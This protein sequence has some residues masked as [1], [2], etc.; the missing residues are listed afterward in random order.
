MAFDDTDPWSVADLQTY[1]SGIMGPSH[2]APSQAPMHGAKTWLLLK[3]R[4]PSPCN[5]EG[6]PIL[7]ATGSGAISNPTS[8][9]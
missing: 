1:L 7:C 3:A 8:T 6:I 5:L 4:I 2:P 9:P